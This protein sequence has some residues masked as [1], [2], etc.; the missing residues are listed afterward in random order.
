MSEP[1]SACPFP[2]KIFIPEKRIERAC[3]EALESVKLMPTE[4]EP[5]R[6]DRFIEKFFGI[7]IDYDDLEE[8][9]EEGV[10]GACRFDRDGNV[11]AIL[12][13]RTLGEDDT[14]LGVRR[15]RSTLAHEA[16]HGI[17]HGE[18]FAEKLQ[19]DEEIARNGF[20]DTVCRRGVFAEGFACRGLGDAGDGRTRK[21]WWE[22]QA[23]MA[24]AALLLPRNLVDPLLRDI[25][26][27]IKMAFGTTYTPDLDDACGGIADAF[28]VSVTM[29]RYRIEKEYE[30]LMT[31]PELL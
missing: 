2:R 17:F 23:N 26:K 9:F 12:V 29:A 8:R 3:A 16:G 21:E 28:N 15:E 7:D 31:Q 4:A 19:A 30:R 22:I 14:Q 11:S 27:P 1:E 10:M 13:D 25:V 6:I 20:E 24:M 5:I 18:L